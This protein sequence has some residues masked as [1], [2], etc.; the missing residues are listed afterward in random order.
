MNFKYIAGSTLSIISFGGFLYHGSPIINKLDSIINSINLTSIAIIV[1]YGVFRSP[2][3]TEIKLRM[4]IT[5]AMFC[6]YV[7]PSVPY[8][9]YQYLYNT[10]ESIPRKY[11]LFS[12]L[13]CLLTF[14]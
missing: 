8:L 2:L 7:I 1:N 5:S 14:L 6:A 4:Y 13:G 11:Q 3:T 10:R 9:K 12:I